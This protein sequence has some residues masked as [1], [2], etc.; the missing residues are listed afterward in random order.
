MRVM[1][2]VQHLLGIG[3][4]R[5][6]ALFSAAMRKLG[7]ELTVVLGGQDIP[8]IDFG[9]VNVIHLPPAHVTDHTFKPL[10]DENDVPIDDA[11]K[12]RRKEMLLNVYKDFN[13]DVILL[14]MFPFG[15]RQFR[16]ELLPL[17]E[18]AK[19][20]NRKPLIVSSI[21]D[22]LVHKAKPERTLEMVDLVRQHFDLVLVHGDENF[23]P[24]DGSFPEMHQ[25]A[26]L[27]RYTG[28]IAM[29]ADSGDA[30]TAGS[31]E[32]IVS[33]GSGATG[34]PLF[35]I[36]LA[37]RQQCLLADKT[38]RLITGPNLGESNFQK[39]REEAPTG[40]IVE[41]FRRDLPQ[42][43][44]NCLLSISRGGYNTVMDIIRARAK[45]II[46]PYDDGEESEQ[47]QR[48][49]MLADRNVLKVIKSQ[50]L[51]V[52]ELVRAIDESVAMDFSTIDSIDLGGAENAARI[53]AGGL[54]G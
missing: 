11:W 41:K 14:E 10:L 9:D 3:H 38:W 45:A 23:I 31:D 34:A 48:A 25:I 6:A 21:R 32:V 42:M 15:R 40:V 35:D 27:V 30:T 49:N 7:L 18:A 24:L 8:D 47:L 44:G 33:A 54:D 52:A 19:G 36:V 1:F 37:A 20:Q 43:L 28:Y 2:Y 53:I 16:F 22:I 50:S 51:S 39:L 5:R 13:P 4:I 17:L 46:I 12:A 26:D 29:P